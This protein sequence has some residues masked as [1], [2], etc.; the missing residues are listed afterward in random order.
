MKWGKLSPDL[1]ATCCICQ[2]LLIY[3]REWLE[4]GRGVAETDVL[5]RGLDV[6][7]DI[8]LRPAYFGRHLPARNW[9]LFYLIR[10]ATFDLGLRKGKNNVGNANVIDRAWNMYVGSWLISLIKEGHYT[11]HCRIESEQ[12]SFEFHLLRSLLTSVINFQQPTFKR[13]SLI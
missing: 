5:A 2:P 11:T 9:I 6:C 7:K 12:K 4:R 10:Y 13:G 3:R 8:M 1:L